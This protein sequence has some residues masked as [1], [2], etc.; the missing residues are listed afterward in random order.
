MIG[1]SHA[2]SVAAEIAE[3]LH[4]AAE[5]WLGI[6]H[7]ILTMQAAEEFG[8]LLRVGEH[9]GRARA[10]ELLAPI[11]TFQTGDEFAAKD[12]AQDLHR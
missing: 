9:R 1:D 6:N 10:A 4:G 3:H 5:G 7:P 2:V 8:K 11:E 12:P